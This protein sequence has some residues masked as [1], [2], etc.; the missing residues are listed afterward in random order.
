M[1][2]INN[3]QIHGVDGCIGEKQL[4]NFARL[5]AIDDE[6]FDLRRQFNTAVTVKQEAKLSSRYRA[7]FL[8]S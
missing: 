2:L 6:Q 8:V 3:G 1:Q 5:Q 4:R 7:L